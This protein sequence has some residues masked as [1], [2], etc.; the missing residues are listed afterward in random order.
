MKVTVFGSGYVGLVIGAR[1]AEAGNHVPCQCD[2]RGSWRAQHHG[3]GANVG[4]TA[5][6]SV[7]RSVDYR[8]N[9]LPANAVTLTLSPASPQYV[10]T[11]V[12]FTAQASDGSGTYECRFRRYSSL[13][14]V[15]DRRARLLHVQHVDV[16]HDR[17][18]CCC[19]QHNGVGA[20]RR[21]NSAIQ[22][23][24]RDKLHIEFLAACNGGDLVSEPG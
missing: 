6:H 12:T 14:T 17:L 23:V 4:S 9:P 19:L 16:E 21:I 18:G 13:D 24:H 10:G 22:H 11:T 2:R 3:G 1:L 15:V 5:S 20:Q 8:L 7:Y